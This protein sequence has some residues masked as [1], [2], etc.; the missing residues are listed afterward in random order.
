MKFMTLEDVKKIVDMKGTTDQD[1]LDRVAQLLAARFE[2]YLNRDLVKLTDP[3]PP[4][5]PAQR[6]EYF[7]GG[8]KGRELLSL[9]AYPN[10][11]NVEIRDDPLRAFDTTTIVDPTDYYVEDRSGL[12]YALNGF[13]FQA[14]VA[15]IQVKY[16]GGYAVR[17]V[18]DAPNTEDLVQIPEEWLLAYQL[19]LRFLW[20]RRDNV[21]M[22]SMAHSSGG[23]AA[24]SPIRLLPE[25]QNILRGARRR[26][27]G[28]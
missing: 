15:N 23:T 5:D 14:G 11:V 9:R 20:S 24:Y 22:L 16:N 25:V 26:N 18:G 27:I 28:K 6:T 7:H 17:T 12:V 4:A 2:Q 13:V 19:Q 1:V 10:I 3:E 8:P 21:A